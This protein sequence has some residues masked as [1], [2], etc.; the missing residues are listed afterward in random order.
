M[1]KPSVR[2]ITEY[3]RKIGMK[4]SNYIRKRSSTEVRLGRK[5]KR[6]FMS[7][8]RDGKIKREKM[9]GLILDI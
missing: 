3:V 9:S 5:I 1:E 4:S 2:K 8:E 7:E 6:K